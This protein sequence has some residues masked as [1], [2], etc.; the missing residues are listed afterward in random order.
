MKEK[1]IYKEMYG[2]AVFMQPYLHYYLTFGICPSRLGIRN[3]DKNRLYNL[4]VEKYRLSDDKVIKSQGFDSEKNEL[5]HS[6]ILFDVGDYCSVFFNSNWGCYSNA[7][8]VEIIYSHKT[9]AIFLKEL[10]AL[11]KQ[12][13][14]KEEL[15]SE[16]NLICRNETLNLN[17]FEIPKLELDLELNYNDDFMEIDRIVKSRLSKPKDKG[18][19]L[20]HGLPGTGKTNYI[21]HLLT[22]VNKK[23]IYLPPDLA[24]EIGSPGF[25][26]FLT[27]NSDSVLIVED[28]ENVIMERSGGS[29]GAMSNL[30]NLCDGLL[31]DCLN[32]QIVCTFNTDI[33]KIDQALM[34]K[35]RLI[36]K[37]EFKKLEVGKAQKLSHSLGYL[38][39]ITAEMSLSEIYNQEQKAFSEETKPLI[40]FGRST[41]TG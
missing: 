2:N 26:T 14:I 25:L 30:L 15:R 32:I 21:R 41:S 5:W 4:I 38:N 33:S 36:A 12:C 20:L 17:A 35:G 37:Y 40:G 1:F 19:V 18:I 6:F 34:R 16:I 3:I 11:V 9:S 22:S 13:I 8:L 24:Y 31:S 29:N 39:E 28:A 7:K 27:D 10:E 23:M